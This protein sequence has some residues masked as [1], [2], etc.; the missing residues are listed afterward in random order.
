M[1]YSV[2]CHARDA[3]RKCPL[4]NGVAARASPSLPPG[5]AAPGRHI[6]HT[7]WRDAACSGGARALRAAADASPAQPAPI[8]RAMLQHV[9][10]QRARKCRCKAVLVLWLQLPH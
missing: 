1:C 10:L 6:Q 8:A 4:K 9:P 3:A 5:G 7:Y 2:I